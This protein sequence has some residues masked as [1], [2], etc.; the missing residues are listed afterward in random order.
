YDQ[1]ANCRIAGECRDNA[2]W[3]LGPEI[4]RSLPETPAGAHA[5]AE[6]VAEERS[7]QPHEILRRA[8]GRISARQPPG[9]RAWREIL[10]QAG[11]DNPLSP[12][13][14]RF[15]PDGAGGTVQVAAV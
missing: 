9:R 2:G 14:R 15:P 3:L 13:G 12:A 1:S 5:A 4:H 6:S 10:R 7:A 11:Q 8:R